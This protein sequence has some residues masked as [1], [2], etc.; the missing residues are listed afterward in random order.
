MYRNFEE[1]L[2][3]AKSMEGTKISVQPAADLEV[4]EAVKEASEL[5]LADFIFVERQRR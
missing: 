4:L 1:V 3:K 5:G 2:A